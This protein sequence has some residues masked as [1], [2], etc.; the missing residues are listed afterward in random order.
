MRK[1]AKKSLPA[2]NSQEH[3]PPSISVLTRIRKLEHVNQ[4][5]QSAIINKLKLPKLS[6]ESS[7][8][9]AMT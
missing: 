4:A 5:R 1:K 2:V 7:I 6:N 3:Q 8:L 9:K